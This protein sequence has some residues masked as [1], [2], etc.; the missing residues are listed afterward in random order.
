M[1]NIILPGVYIT[2]RDEGLITVGGVS[3]GNV[4]IVGTSLEGTT[5]KVEMLGSY[6]EATAIFGAQAGVDYSKA[7]PAADKVTLVKALEILFANGASTVYAVRAA[8]ETAD[9]YA[10]ALDILSNEIVNIVLLAGQDASNKDMV[11]KLDGSH[12]LD[13]SHPAGTDRGHRLQRFR[14]CGRDQGQ[15]GGERFGTH[16]VCR[17]G[18]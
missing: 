18:H 1:A 6:A 12:H 9:S 5:N 16:C 17:T 14:R 13:R 4:G 15:Q 7:S 3:T 11:T 2:V 8:A 10:A